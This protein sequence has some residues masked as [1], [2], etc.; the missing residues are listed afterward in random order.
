[1]TDRGIPFSAPMVRALLDGRK[2]QT[3]RLLTP[4]PV[5]MDEDCEQGFTLSA[6]WTWGPLDRWRDPDEFAMAAARHQR[7][8]VGDRLWVRESYYQRGGW[9]P[10]GEI[11]PGGAN[12]WA[13]VPADPDEFT[14]DAP[15]D[16]HSARQK[17]RPKDIRW[18]K[19]LG[20]FMPRRYS[21]ITLTVTDVRVQHL[22]DI[23]EAD[24]IAEGLVRY[25]MEG[26]GGMAIDCWHWLPWMDDE[27]TFTTPQAAYR[28][29]WNTL[30]DKPGERWE[31]NPWICAISFAT[32][33]GNIDQEACTSDMASLV[34]CRRG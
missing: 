21:R 31:D 23:S 26:P 19:R 29:L 9:F 28:A 12:K 3:R 6:G 15:A 30:Y 27:Q 24:A 25:V 17:N 5:W 22:Q 33:L 8:A 20:R 1:M 34:P 32:R 11:T 13:F 16:F 7:Y 14:F 2:S 18:Y 10:T 4:Q